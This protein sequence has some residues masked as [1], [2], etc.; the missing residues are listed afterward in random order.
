[1]SL[2]AGTEL[3]SCDVVRLLGSGGMG[4]VY[5]ALDRQLNRHVAVKVLRAE[6]TTQAH[7]LAPLEQEARAASALSHPN[8]CHIYHLGETPDG[9]RYI[10]MEYVEGETLDQRLMAHRLTLG[11][12]LDIAI[13][14]AAALTAAHTAGIVHR[15][16]KP[17]N[18]MIRRDR[19]V[20][21]LDFGLAKLAPAAMALAPHG[22]TQTVAPTEPGSLVGTIDYMSPEQARGQAVDARTD[23]WAFGVVLYE[24]VA[25]RPPFAGATRA[26]VLA[27]ILER[28][29][30]PLAR[31]ESQMPAELQRMVGKAL[32]KDPEKRYQGMQD[33]L[34]DL[35]A[36]RDE[37]VSRNGRHPSAEDSTAPPVAQ[38]HRFRSLVPWTLAGV[39]LVTSAALGV[40]Y[41]RQPRADSPVVRFALLPPP[42][43]R[44]GNWAIDGE[45]LAVAPDGH[46]VVLVVVSGERRHLELRA[47][48]SAVSRVLPGT[49]DARNPFW[50]PDSRWIAF[51]AGNA[52]KKLDTT[53]GQPQTICSLQSVASPL[54]HG[55]WSA[56]GTIVFVAAHEARADRQGLL[57]VSATGGESVPA[58]GTPSNEILFWPEFLPDGRHFLYLQVALR[59][60]Q[61][62]NREQSELMLG[63]LDGDAPVPVMRALSKA[64]YLDT[65]Y[66]LF[67]RE[68]ALLAQRFDLAAH[69][70]RGE[71]ATVAEGVSHFQRTGFSDFSVSRNGVLAF[72][73]ASR[74]SQLVWVTRDGAEAGV[75]GEP[76]NYAGF[77]LSPDGQRLVAA[78]ALPDTNTANTADL[79]LL[80]LARGTETRFT[81]QPVNEIT[82]VWS[83]DS[84]DI[85]FVADEGAPPFLHVKRVGQVGDGVPLIPPAGFPQSAWDWAD[86]AEGTFAIYADG[87][88]GTG[89]DLMVIPMSGDR[90]PRVFLRTPFD[91]IDA[92]FSP[93][94]RW[95]A[96]VTKES[97]RNEVVVRPFDGSSEPRQVSTAGGMSPRWSRRSHELFFIGSDGRLMRSAFTASGIGAPTGLFTVDARDG[98]YFASYE[99]SDDGQRFLVNRGSG[100]SP[101]QVIVNWPAALRQ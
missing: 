94:G 39:L 72:Q 86:T 42:G 99:V 60:V 49:E 22:P 40:L 20:K 45:S 92:R 78:R 73:A 57:K 48:D 63:S 13:Q 65:G 100:P 7:R 79:W 91:E 74:P 90:K 15:D 80:D 19:L 88:P 93:D 47:L 70:L 83:P 14:M 50:S 9:Q 3:G 101:V 8:I 96:Y 2:A 98:L 51:I 95:V 23:V 54:I 18:V 52:L 31:L 58:P 10:A 89:M 53:G 5:L 33:L 82:P 38:F 46:A 36:L 37:I 69:Q 35:E 27:A 44:F 34:L 29:P 25:G 67:V 41:S 17:A 97:G 6:V 11:E 62:D 12:A 76:A 87:S 81:S 85:L 24:M 55:T 61:S 66:L 43:S 64:I 56:D 21:V 28:E 59:V 84:R 30:V 32:R 16:V 68:G 71:P 4:D 75:V 1:M 77:R 26:D